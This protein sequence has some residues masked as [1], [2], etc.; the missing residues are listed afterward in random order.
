LPTTTSWNGF[1][2]IVK[3]HTLTVTDQAQRSPD[4]GCCNSKEKHDTCSNQTAHCQADQGFDNTNQG[5]AQ[6]SELTDNEETG[7]DWKSGQLE[8]QWG[9]PGRGEQ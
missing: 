2:I 5:E 1:E 3:A 4:P 8:L 9:K 6:V 7:N